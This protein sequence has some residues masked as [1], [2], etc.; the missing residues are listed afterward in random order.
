MTSSFPNVSGPSHVR[1]TLLEGKNVLSLHLGDPL[2][3]DPSEGA[4]E[5]GPTGVSGD[6]I[7]SSTEG[8]GVTSESFDK[9]KDTSSESQD[10]TATA[11]NVASSMKM[12]ESNDKQGP[13]MLF[14]VAWDTMFTQRKA[15]F[16]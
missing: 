5:G 11:D 15:T 3:L 13:S 2:P 12:G 4:S 1:L 14:H 9:K 10:N 16:D 7:H 6:T 8:A